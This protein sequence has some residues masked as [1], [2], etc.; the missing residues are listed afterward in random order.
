MM[1][2]FR[3][4]QQALGE[5]CVAGNADLAKAAIDARHA[6]A[7]AAEARLQVMAD[8]LAAMVERARQDRTAAEQKLRS[9][10]A[11]AEASGRA[12]AELPSA[13]STDATPSS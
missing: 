7:G 2:K 11:Q 9:A 3:S 4:A 8:E 12:A 6:A 13:I 1:K 5:A 10:V